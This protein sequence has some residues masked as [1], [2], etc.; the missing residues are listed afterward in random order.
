MSDDPLVFEY[1]PGCGHRL[2]PSPAYMVLFTTADGPGAMPV[3]HPCA[4][5]V[6]H[7]TETRPRLFGLLDA[8]AISRH[9]VWPVRGA[10]SL[11]RTSASAPALRRLKPNHALVVMAYGSLYL[12]Q[13]ESFE[14]AELQIAEI[15]EKAQRPLP[16]IALLFDVVGTPEQVAR[17]SARNLARHLLTYA[18]GEHA[19]LHSCLMGVTAYDDTRPA[20]DGFI[21]RTLTWDQLDGN[22]L[23]LVR[24]Q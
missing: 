12:D 21:T 5:V 11:A 17:G 2:S 24:G 22:T 14:F 1:C 15:I 10:R 4:S 18:Q 20:R 8:A 23:A 9:D 19:G 13:A 16:E 7:D 3:C 6:Q